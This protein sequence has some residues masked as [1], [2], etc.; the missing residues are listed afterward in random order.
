MK[1][2]E[3]ID[4]LK[5]GDIIGLKT[6]VHEYQTRAMRTAYLIT[7]DKALAEEIVQDTF[8]QIYQRIGQF[9]V[10]RPFAPWFLRIVANNAAK[11]VRRG[12]RFVSLES[13]S[14]NDA[15]PLAEMMP[16]RMPDLDEQVE[17]KMRREKIWESLK[18][19]SPKQRTA[20][21]LRYYLDMSEAEMA[22]KLSVAPGTVKWR[23]YT[24]RERLRTLLSF[25]Y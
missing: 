12:H 17:S 21:I 20:I 15:V 13:P 24:A 22:H 19:L 1:D 8:I 6:L 11:A 4:R 2:E 18:R 5:Q 23:L 25:N 9:D 14:I 7:H 16:D 3:A 10:D